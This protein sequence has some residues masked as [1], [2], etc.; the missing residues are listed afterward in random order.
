MMTILVLQ[1]ALIA[2]VLVWLAFQ[3]P[4]DKVCAGFVVCAAG[5][6]LLGVGLAG[7]WVYPPR[8]ALLLVGLLYAVLSYRVWRRTE[9]A[10]AGGAL[11]RAARIGGILTWAIVGGALTWQSVAGHLK[12]RGDTF[13]LAAP[14]RGEGFCVIS[15]GASAVLNFH[16]ETLAV[17]KEAYRGQS[18]GADFIARSPL[19]F[20]TTDGEWWRPAPDDPRSYRI[21]GTPVVAPCA[22]EVASAR[23]GVPDQAA[24]ESTPSPMAGNHVILSCNGH[25]VL[26]A[27]LKQGSISVA[28]GQQ[29]EVG[30]RLGEVGN[31]GATDEPHLHVSVQRAADRTAPLGGQPVHLTFNGRYLARGE[32]L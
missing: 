2:S 4:A 1:L 26:L 29:V 20:R 10:D 17:G 18:Y 27:H 25:E 3:R 14:L 21:F 30:A 32:C 24:G 22:G 6:V 15:G 28:P 11:R 12:P 5:L 13:D 16:M 8:W 7:L 31:T 19:G 9:D 23:D